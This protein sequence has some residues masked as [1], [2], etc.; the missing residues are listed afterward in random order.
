M[1][2]HRTEPAIRSGLM[3]WAFGQ[4]ELELGV[5]RSDCGAFHAE[6]TPSSSTGA[7]HDASSCTRQI[8]DGCMTT[9][10]P[11]RRSAAPTSVVLPDV[12]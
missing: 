8:A 2:I 10:Q 12:E 11:N 4:P 6:H 1:E 9:Q 7:V 3:H 5:S